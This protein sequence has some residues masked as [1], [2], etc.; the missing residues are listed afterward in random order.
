M[1]D[2]PELTCVL[3]CQGIDLAQVYKSKLEAAGIPV[4]LR[5]EAAGPIFG[6]IIDG[7][8]EVKVMVPAE[9]AAG[10]EDI[11]GG[12]EAEAFEG[13]EE[14]FGELDEGEEETFPEE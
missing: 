2:E 9:F 11:L 10:A 3:T 5:Y 14:L 4:L 12:S 8:G 6:I 1:A 7:L 13:E